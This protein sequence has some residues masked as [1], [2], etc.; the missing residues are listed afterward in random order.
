MAAVPI[1]MIGLWRETLLR[2]VMNLH[3]A[4]ALTCVLTML[5]S[6]HPSA[7]AKPLLVNGKN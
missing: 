5:F 6:A 1:S 3:A 2:L 4:E 7:R